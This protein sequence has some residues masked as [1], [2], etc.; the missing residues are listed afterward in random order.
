[1]SDVPA[2][3]AGNSPSNTPGTMPLL[4]GL[5]QVLLLA[6]LAAAI[7][8]ALWLV[9]WSRGDDWA[10]L[11]S[12]LGERETSQVVDA[13]AATGVPNR[14]DGSTGQV[15]V[16]REQVREARMRLAAQGLPQSDALG[17]EMI[18]KDS[19]FG[20]SQFMEGARYQSAL[21]TELA[22][23]I[24][25]VQGVQGARVHLALPRQTAFVRD[26]KRTSASVM[27]QLYAGRRLEEGQVQAIV[28]LVAS[29]VPELEAG[30]VTVVDQAG[31]LLS[32]TQGDDALA[33]SSR[34][35]EYTRELEADYQ[36]RIE[37]LLAPLVGAGKVRAGVTAELDFTQQ[38]V[39]REDFDP[40]QQVVRSEQTS[41]DQRAAGVGG[42][43]GVP[44]SLSN[45]PPGTVPLTGP[46][47]PGT[48][49]GGT[50]VAPTAAAGGTA[51]V[52]AA[53]TPAGGAANS[54]VAQRAT[55]N[56]EI[57]RTISHVRNPV[58][59]VRR[60]SV[61]VVIDN[62][63]VTGADGKPRSQ[64]VSAA[65]L[66][67]YTSLVRDVIGFDEQRGDRVQVLNESFQ[68]TEPAAAALPKEPLWSQPATQGYI[69]QGVAVVLVL[70][71]AAFVLRPV[72]KGLFPT[73]VASAAG[74]TVL[75]A[76]RAAP[77][78]VLLEPGL[79]RQGL[80]APAAPLAA[81][82]SPQHYEQQVANARARVG[83]DPRRAAQVVKEWVAADG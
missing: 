48:P 3:G 6:G 62:R 7:A 1:M 41:M 2:N 22:R 20:T 18:Q 30:D 21:E 17:I 46:G 58:G 47:A 8:V 64:P 59:N 70:L 36:R 27:L 44:G 72:M 73:P 49:T 76:H 37:S 43:E 75:L 60:L 45:Q 52:G 11:Y 9:L 61:A 81:L 23:T 80:P 51:V 33:G 53:G 54:N 67:R 10:P 34:Q 78:D 28:H 74:T 77:G 71:V 4:P 16:P 31:N 68:A 82:P 40:T 79:A 65:E 83:Q 19:P 32:G 35:R 24:G 50:A 26:E 69:R 14:L 42:A 25:K 38:E 57:D 66:A 29:S 13:L 12:Q 56:F 39:T 5:R 15:M 55:R 63:V